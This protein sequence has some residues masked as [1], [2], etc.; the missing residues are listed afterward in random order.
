MP[1]KEVWHCSCKVDV[2]RDGAGRFE[3]GV[4]VCGCTETTSTVAMIGGF[5][6]AT[7]LDTGET[8]ILTMFRAHAR[9]WV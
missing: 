2:W 8:L 7:L 6:W 1:T 9:I 3:G 4:C 5:H